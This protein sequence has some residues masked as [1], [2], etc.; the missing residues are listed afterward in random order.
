MNFITSCLRHAVWMLV[1]VIGTA[2]SAQISPG[3]DYR[4]INPPQP[5][6]SGK[7]IEVLEFF[8]Y[9]CPHCNASGACRRYST[10]RGCP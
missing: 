3:K 5:T 4:A 10:I 9:G 1:F 2:A 7:R 8:W 6:D